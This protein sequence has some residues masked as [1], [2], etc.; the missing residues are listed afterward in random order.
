M[1]GPRLKIIQ[2]SSL[3]KEGQKR[4]LKIA[5]GVTTAYTLVEMVGGF[6]TQSLALLADAGHMLSDVGALGIALF[7]IRLA[8]RPPTQEKTY[9]YHRAEI[10]AALANGL[11]LWLIAGLIL[12][13]AYLRFLSPPEVNGLGM[14][15][16]ATAGLGVN[17]GVALMLKKRASGSLNLRGAFLHVTSDALGS[18]GA[19][20]A[21][22]IILL[23]GWYLADPIVSVLI[24]GLILYSSWGLVRESV[25]IL[26]E[27]TPKGIKLGDVRAAL[28]QVQGFTF[29]HVEGHGAQVEHD[30][31][32]SVRDKVV[33]YTPRVRVDV[34]LEDA[35]VDTVLDTLRKT[36]NGFDGQG[37]YWVTTVE[38]S[39]GL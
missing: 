6:L 31:F 9:G 20:S 10:L 15:L 30:P 24:G 21:G 29:S 13:E 33:G 4:S 27:A 2:K 23:T 32:L 11:T 25:D 26:M 28:E 5:L 1:E 12:R 19:I 38:K 39:G 18:V 16:V 3:A 7:A 17:V 34:L 14:L 35:D 22:A 36:R 37:I 8:E